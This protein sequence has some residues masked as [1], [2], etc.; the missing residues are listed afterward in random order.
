MKFNINETE[1]NI[2]VQKFRK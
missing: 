1:K 2:Y